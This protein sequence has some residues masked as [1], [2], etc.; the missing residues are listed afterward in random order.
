MSTSELKQKLI[1]CISH[2]DNPDLLQEVFRLL[3]L[4]TESLDVYKLNVEQRQAIVEGQEDINEGR[5]LTNE[6]VDD[7]IDRWLKG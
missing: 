1:T 7:E 2:T 6:Q 5:S 4:E 3:E